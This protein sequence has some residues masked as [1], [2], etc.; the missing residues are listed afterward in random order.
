M[1]VR[2]KDI[3]NRLGVSQTTVSHVLRGREAEYRIGSATADRIREAAKLL[4]YHPSALARSLKHHR[5][6][7]LALA[8]GDLANP[9]WA[10]L[11]VAAQM[12]AERHGYMLVVNHTGESLAKERQLLDMLRQKRVDGLILSAGH[13]KPRDL[14]DLREEQRPLVLVDRT[15]DGLDLPSVV[16]DSMAGLRMAVDHLVGLGHRRI[17]FLGG[18]N[19]IITFRE[20]RRGYREAMID[21]GLRFGPFAVAEATPE[22]A[23]QAVKG[24]FGKSSSPTALIAANIWL[25]MGALRGTPDDVEIVGFDDIYL[26]DMLRRRV[27]TIAQPVEELGVQAVRLL[28]EEI[29]HPGTKQHVVLPPRIIVR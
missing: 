21:H 25:T 10:G 6:Y 17:G 16:S 13:L 27:T 12:E 28:L 26:A 14:T 4:H 11:A 22:A 2:M 20:R 8:V 5:A 29:A 19:E 23:E 24:L 15:I 1:S 7:S 3:A 9:F 18:P